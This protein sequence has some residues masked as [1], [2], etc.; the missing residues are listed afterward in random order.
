MVCLNRLTASL[1]IES[2]THKA[3]F[4]NLVVFGRLQQ[5]LAME[6]II[7]R[8]VPGKDSIDVPDVYVVLEFG[9]V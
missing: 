3:I 7:I 1:V 4:P 2:G 9:S 5:Q 8:E 6:V